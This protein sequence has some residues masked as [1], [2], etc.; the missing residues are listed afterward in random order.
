ML[1]GWEW[2]I[3]PKWGWRKRRGYDIKEN[4]VEKVNEPQIIYTVDVVE[5]N[6][7]LDIKIIN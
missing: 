7:L 3:R 6:K 2:N 1:V 4:L 5:K